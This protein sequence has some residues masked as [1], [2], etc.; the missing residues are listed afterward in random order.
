MYNPLAGPH[1]RSG[2]I[3][4]KNIHVEINRNTPT[5]AIY[6]CPNSPHT[7]LTLLPVGRDAAVKGG[8]L[9]WRHGNQSCLLTGAWM[10]LL[11]NKMNEHRLLQLQGKPGLFH[12]VY[13]V[14]FP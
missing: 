13:T 6:Q 4:R 11:D 5:P 10:R 14:V 7:Y 1:V 9:V 2:G 12:A 3:R 8:D